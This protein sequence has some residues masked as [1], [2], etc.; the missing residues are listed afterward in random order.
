MQNASTD[1]FAAAIRRMS[2]SQHTS[3]K[4]EALMLQTTDSH[5]APA[6]YLADD[7]YRGLAGDE[8]I[9]PIKHVSTAIGGRYGQPRYR[10]DKVTKTRL[11]RFLH[12][13]RVTYNSE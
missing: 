13:R 12:H 7:Q 1:T 6:E 11:Q 4:I 2:Q 5:H 8:R 10:V 3:R 9:A